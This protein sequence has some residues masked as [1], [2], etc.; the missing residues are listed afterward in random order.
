MLFCFDVTQY[1][2]LHVVSMESP[3][4]PPGLEVYNS[5]SFYIPTQTG[6]CFMIDEEFDIYIYESQLLTEAEFNECRDILLNSGIWAMNCE[7]N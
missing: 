1:T 7:D 4:A 6:S 3:E 5:T 2:G